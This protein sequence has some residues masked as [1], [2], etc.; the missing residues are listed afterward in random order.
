M[1]DYMGETDELC[2]FQLDE[3]ARKCGNYNKIDALYYRVPG[4][5]FDFG[6][7]I[8]NNDDDIR[9]MISLIRKHQLLRCM[10]FMELMS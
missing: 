2:T 4:M 7:R 10:C 3:L 9:D 5:S 1:K 8:I 6:L